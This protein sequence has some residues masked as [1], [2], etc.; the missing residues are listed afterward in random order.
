MYRDGCSPGFFDLGIAADFVSD[1]NR[2][3]ERHG[4]DS[5]SYKPVPDM[6][7]G[8]GGAGQIHLRK[9]PSA[10]NIPV[11]IGVGGHGDRA[12][13]GFGVVAGL[14]CHGYLFTGW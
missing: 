6:V 7:V 9:H 4:F 11:G 10:E 5:H 8:K 13:G 3:M 14:G 1:E 2:Q 12:Q